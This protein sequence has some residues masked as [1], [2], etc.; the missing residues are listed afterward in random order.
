MKKYI[1]GKFYDEHEVD[2]SKLKVLFNSS[3]KRASDY[4]AKIRELEEIVA[5][6]LAKQNEEV[7]E[8]A[9]EAIEETVATEDV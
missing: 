6:L 7:Q 4:E 1:D 2:T 3:K 9:S 5:S 8:E